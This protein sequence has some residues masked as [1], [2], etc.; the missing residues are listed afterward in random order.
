[1]IYIWLPVCLAGA[2]VDSLPCDRD[3]AQQEI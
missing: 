1:M 3:L 2:T